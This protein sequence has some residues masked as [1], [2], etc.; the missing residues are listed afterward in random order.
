MTS[1]K[2]STNKNILI[3]VDE[4]ENSRRAVSYVAQFLGGIEGFKV[5]ILHVI[6]IP[7][8]DF[9]PNSTERE[10]WLSQHRGKVDAMLGG[11]RQ[12]LIRAG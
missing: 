9:F 1:E 2:K 10:K 7:E 8:D 11:Y 5:T 4:S 3:A 12:I 6:P